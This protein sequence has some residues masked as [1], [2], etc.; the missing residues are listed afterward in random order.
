[1][2]V[3]DYGHRVLSHEDRYDWFRFR[4]YVGFNGSFECFGVLE[5]F[6]G[7]LGIRVGYHIVFS[8]RYE[9]VELCPI[10]PFRLFRVVLA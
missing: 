4:A 7:F 1:M 3:V 10:E 2:D 5:G 6:F 9:Q 8:V